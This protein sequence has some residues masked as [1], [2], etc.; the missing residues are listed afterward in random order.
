MIQ[1]KVCMIGGF[2]VGKTSLVQRFVTSLFSEK[3][4][5]TIG[6]KVD[7][8]KVHLDG[9]TVHLL[10]WDIHGEDPQQPL[11]S[12]YIKGASGYLLVADGTRRETLDGAYRLQARIKKII[13]DVPFVLLVNKCDLT[14]QWEIRPEDEAE[15]KRKGWTCFITSAKSGDGVEDAFQALTRKIRLGDA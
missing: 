6:V 3:Y 14:R 9:E 2:A 8:K 11:S 4:H 15:F 7:K 13:G 1:K 5:S 12:T 10:I